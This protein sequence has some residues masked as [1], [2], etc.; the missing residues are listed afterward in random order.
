MRSKTIKVSA[1]SL[2]CV[3]LILVAVLLVLNKK[4]ESAYSCYYIPVGDGKL[5]WGMNKEEIV[6]VMGE[7]TS[8]EDKEY[9][10]HLTYDIPISSKLG[11]CSKLILYVGYDKSTDAEQQNGLGGLISLEMEIYGTTKEAVIEKLSMFYG[12]LTG[13]SNQIERDLQ[14]ANTDYFNKTYYSD[15]WKI[16]TL[17]EAEYNQLVQ[18]YQKI[19]SGIL[20]DEEESLMYIMISGVEVGDAYTCNV[21]LDA[22]VLSCLERVE[23]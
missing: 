11:S 14:K 17:S 22:R 7:P 12:D 4:E 23:K 15:E 1:I 18:S 6:A 13:G 2:L 5:S 16:G 20:L 9:G 3:C 19:F 8:V 10:F 21:R